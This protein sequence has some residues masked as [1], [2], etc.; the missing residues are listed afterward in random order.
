MADE[1]TPCCMNWTVY[2]ALA[3]LALFVVDGSLTRTATKLSF[4]GSQP[5]SDAMYVPVGCAFSQCVRNPITSLALAGLI[6]VGPASALTL[7]QARA[8]CVD[9]AGKQ[10]Y[11]D[12][13]GHPISR[14]PVDRE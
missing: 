4:R 7:E 12:C 2:G 6:A 10:S 14:K 11:N 1:R 5:G 13:M 9:T 3:R 8:H